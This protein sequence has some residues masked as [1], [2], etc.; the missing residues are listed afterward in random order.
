MAALIQWP[1]CLQP[2]CVGRS[3][4]YMVHSH[5]SCKKHSRSAIRIA[6]HIYLLAILHCDMLTRSLAPNHSPRT[7]NSAL[8]GLSA[9][10]PETAWTMEY[11]IAKGTALN[12]CVV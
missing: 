8:H 2:S 1:C 3:V 7:D 12:S 4:L 6:Y 10:N 5:Q 11:R 9:Q